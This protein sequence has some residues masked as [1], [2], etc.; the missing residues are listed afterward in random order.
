MYISDF[1]TWFGVNKIV[2]QHVTLEQQ[3]RECWE[4]ASGERKELE[5]KIE[6]LEDEIIELEND[7]NRLQDYAY[8]N[9][10][11]ADK[12]TSAERAF[13]DLFSRLNEAKDNAD[14]QLIID[15]ILPDFEEA[16]DDLES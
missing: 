13:R 14:Y 4:N 15:D 16:L 11:L 5:K 7:N 6:K 8:E 9:D 1:D 3:F 12:I 2:N 10:F